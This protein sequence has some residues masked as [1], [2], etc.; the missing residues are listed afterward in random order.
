MSTTI[1]GNGIAGVQIDKTTFVG[2]ATLAQLLSYGMSRPTAV[3]ASGKTKKSGLGAKA[4]SYAQLRERIQRTWNKARITRAEAYA[5]YIRNLANGAELGATPP[6][7]IF[8]SHTPTVSGDLLSFPFGTQFIAIDGE[9][10]FEA[11]NLIVDNYPDMGFDAREFAVTF[12][13]GITEDHANKILH[14]F[15]SM[16][17]PISETILG[18]KNVTGKL[19]VAI[20][21]A[22][23]KAKMD[24]AKVNR[25]G[26]SAT[27]N[28]VASFT[29]MMSFVTG[30]AMD[31]QALASHP[32]RWFK[33]LNRSDNKTVNGAATASLATLLTAGVPV[34]LGK[35]P[36]HVWSAAGVK[37]RHG[38]AVDKMDFVAAVA[39][40]KASS[41]SGHGGTRVSVA[42]RLAAI[43]AAL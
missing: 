10:Q 12:F 40:Y 37:A 15:N 13:A 30:Y 1:T 8:A 23:E 33:E 9:T 36:A 43:Y 16:A 39:A 14:D 34:A 21:D 4:V 2:K 26:L 27:R 29:Q 7:T 32:G 31:K 20:H 35:A 3:Y 25:S 19:S 38:K 22:L 6:I 42:D 17:K 41:G 18:S 28:T 5:A 11:R 24:P